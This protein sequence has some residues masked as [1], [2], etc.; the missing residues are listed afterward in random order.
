MYGCNQAVLRVA[1]ALLARHYSSCRRSRWPARSTS[2]RRF[3]GLISAVTFL[4]RHLR[5]APEMIHAAAKGEAYACFV[6]P[7]HPHPFMAMP[8]RRGGP[9]QARLCAARAPLEDGLQRGRLQP[10]GGR[11][12]ADRAR[13]LPGCQSLIRQRREAAGIVDSWPARPSTTRRHGPT[14]DSRRSTTSDGRFRSI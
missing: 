6:R 4:R 14:G 7:E 2:G 13:E 1:R 3:P 10:L 11:G 5:H 9:A 8:E 12:P